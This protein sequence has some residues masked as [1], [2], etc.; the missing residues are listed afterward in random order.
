MT[1]GHQPQEGPAPALPSTGSGVAHAPVVVAARAIEL[2][3]GLLWHAQTDT[4]TPEGMS[5]NLARLALLEQLDRDGQ[6]RGLTLARRAIDAGLDQRRARESRTNPRT[7]SP[8][9]ANALDA[10]DKHGGE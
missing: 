10:L 6:A 7:A 5:I 1:S 4:R 3:Y 8:G 2:A 9:F